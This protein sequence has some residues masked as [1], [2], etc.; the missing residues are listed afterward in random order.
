MCK[1]VTEDQCAVVKPPGPSNSRKYFHWA[2]KGRGI[3]YFPTAAVKKLPQTLWLKNNRNVFSHC[4]GGQKFKIKISA[5]PGSLLRLSIE[6][7]LFLANSTSGICWLALT[8]L[9]LWTHHSSLCLHCPLFPVGLSTV[10]LSQTPPLLSYRGMYAFRAQLGN[11]E[12][13]SYQYL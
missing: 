11:L 10:C 12:R 13:S 7:K 3:Y 9:V 4:H 1:Q 5:G 6:E 2:W 8:F